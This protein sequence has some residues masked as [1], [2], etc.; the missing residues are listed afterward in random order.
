M[1]GPN[2]PP[3]PEPLQIGMLIYP[4]MTLLDLVGPQTALAL[5]GKTHLLWKNKEPVLTDG[6]VTVLPTTT[7]SECPAP[8][9]VLF[10]P[11]GFGTNAMLKDREVLA[12]MRKQGESAR[13][14]TSV[15]SGAL[16]LAAAGLLDGYK[17][18]THWA[19][20][21]ILEALGVEAVRSR[22][23]VDRN[24]CTGGGVT[25]GIDFGLTLLAQLRGEVAARSTQLMM[26]YDPE[27]PFD[28]GSPEGAGPEIV[29]MVSGILKTMNDE[30]V[31][32]ARTIRRKYA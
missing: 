22:V 15:C 30:G 25:A 10:A 13:Y 14:V 18:T 16:I 12:F 32:I 9:D 8:L 3:P 21:D 27:P 5:H 7:F 26:E 29:A 1:A 31:E 17:A 6:G 19:T 23:V 24:R 11:G 4:D 28:S 2:L 20:F